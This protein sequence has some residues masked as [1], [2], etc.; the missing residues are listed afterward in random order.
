VRLLGSLQRP[1]TLA[2]LIAGFTRL[3]GCRLASESTYLPSSITPLEAEQEVLLLLWACLSYNPDFV[4]ALIGSADLPELVLS[5]GYLILCWV[6]DPSSL[7]MVHL[8][9]LCLLRLSTEA[10]FGGCANQPCP[11][12]LP[13]RRPLAAEASSGHLGDLLV[14]CAAAVVLAPPSTALTTI[15]PA[16]LAILNNIAP[17]VK[18]WSA[19]S[20]SSLLAMLSSLAAPATLFATPAAPEPMLALLEALSTSLQY[21]HASNTTLLHR[22]LLHAPLLR[23]LPTA[24]PPADFAGADGFVVTDEWLQSWQQRLPLRCL[25]A[26]LDAVGPKVTRS[27][28]H[29]PTTPP[30]LHTVS[31][32]ATLP[33]PPPI[34][35]RRYMPNEHSEAWMLQV[36]WGVVYS[37]SQDLH[38]ARAVRL[39]QILLLDE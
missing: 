27:A 32:A 3:L 16:A 28:L 23:A 12:A 25:F 6:H 38:D 8:T 26:V 33:P 37:R 31:L 11:R 14:G 15:Y 29:A 24:C 39:V 18:Q 19:S 13:G 7:S 4:T 9:L 1:E 2:F 35:V 10:D 30:A 21:T 20:A 5:L 36:V 17:H 34:A 22:V